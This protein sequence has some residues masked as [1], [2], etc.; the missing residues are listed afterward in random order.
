[1]RSY[2][3]LVAAAL[4]LTLGVRIVQSNDDGWSEM[5]VR[6]FFDVLTAAGHEVVVSAP[7]ENASGKGR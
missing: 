2:L 1:M 4:P 3:L 5:N 7:A 6:T